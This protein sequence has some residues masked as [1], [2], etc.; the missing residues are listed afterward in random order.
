MTIGYTPKQKEKLLNLRWLNP[1]LKQPLN[2]WA[3]RYNTGLLNKLTPKSVVFSFLFL[4]KTTTE[5]SCVGCRCTPARDN[6]QLNK[7]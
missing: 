3:A 1:F 6:T 5:A 4:F 2:Q 7:Q